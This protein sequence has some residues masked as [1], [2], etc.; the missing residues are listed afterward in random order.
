LYF[1]FVLHCGFFVISTLLKNKNPQ[2][3]QVDNSV[4]YFILG[5]LNE[6][7]LDDIEQGKKLINDA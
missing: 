5:I 1:E 2:I 4:F 6:E 7:R 3:Y